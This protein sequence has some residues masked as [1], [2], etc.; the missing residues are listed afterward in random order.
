[1]EE[2]QNESMFGANDTNDSCPGSC[3]NEMCPHLSTRSALQKQHVLPSG[4]T[5]LS[6]PKILSFSS[7]FLLKSSTE[8]WLGK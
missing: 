6:N 4:L 5:P 8:M 1:M 2:P 7:F 3:I